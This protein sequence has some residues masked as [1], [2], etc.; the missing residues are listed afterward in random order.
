VL[1]VHGWHKEVEEA[2]QDLD[3]LHASLVKR[4][5]GVPKHA[6]YLE[7]S[8][9]CCPYAL[10]SSTFHFLRVNKQTE[11]TEVCDLELDEPGELRLHTCGF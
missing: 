9:A 6:L 8:P 1:R 2:E 4:G 7:I 5:V 3:E 10:T 11:K